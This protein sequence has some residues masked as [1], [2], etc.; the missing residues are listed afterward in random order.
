MIKE[1]NGGN[2]MY[3]LLRGDEDGRVFRPLSDENDG[4]VSEL[5]ENPE[6]FGVNKFMTEEDLKE[7]WEKWDPQYWGE[8]NAMLIEFKVCRVVD[9]ETVVKREI[10]P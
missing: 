10:A 2:Q 5:L 3:A 7:G 1:A 6:D 4:M 8:G 9:K